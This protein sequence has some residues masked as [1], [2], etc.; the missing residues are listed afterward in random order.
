V[1]SDIVAPI[2][3]TAASDTWE[4]KANYPIRRTGFAS[5]TMPNAAGQSVLY[6]IGGC[7][8][9]TRNLDLLHKYDVATN[10]WVRRHDLPTPL[11]GM[12]GAGVIG[13]KVYVAGGY[14][15][16]IAYPTN[17]LYMYDPATNSWAQKRSMPRAGYAGVMGVIKGRLYVYNSWYN[18]N[19]VLRNAFYRYDPQLNT[20]ASLSLPH[21]PT[22]GSHQYGAAAVS[23]DRLYVLGGV[24]SRQLDLYDPVTNAWTTLTDTLPI[25]TGAGA[26]ALWAKLYVIGGTVDGVS[27]PTVSIYNPITK[28]WAM[29][30][31]H[32]YGEQFNW[33]LNGITATRVFLDGKPL[34]EMLGGEIGRE[35]WAYFP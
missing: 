7:E 27:V 9:V 12:N 26:A 23:G 19:R 24:S 34:I 3:L 17:A 30:A 5:A 28:K 15:G 18:T 4:R 13:G 10:S 29:G 35:N 20:W 6:I 14:R 33:G 2:Q 21:D 1:V 31:P 22:G 11:C 32:P 16:N 25:R 8:R